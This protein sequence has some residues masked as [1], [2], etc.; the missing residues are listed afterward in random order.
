MTESMEGIIHV[1]I[2]DRMIHGQ[3]ATQWSG[4]LNATR[5]MVIN[6]SI[7]NDDMRKTVVRLAAPANVSTSILSRQKA[8]TNIKNGK[9]KGQRVLLIC[10]SPVDVN[11]LIDNG[12]PIKSVN[13]GNLAQRDGTERI[14]PSVNV[15]PEEKEAFKKLIGRGVEVTV[16]PTPQSPTVYLKDYI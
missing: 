7:V 4:R 12:L 1:R 3:V 10:V 14:R 2:D 13:V 11:Y 9:Y 8:L 16:I 5:I 15:T 6:D